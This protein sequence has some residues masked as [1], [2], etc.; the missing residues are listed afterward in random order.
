MVFRW[1]RSAEGLIRRTLGGAEWKQLADFVSPSFFDVMPARALL[2]QARELLGNA[3]NKPGFRSLVAEIG[4][5]L[6]SRGVGVELRA[7]GEAAG[8]DAHHDLDEAGRRARG[9]RVLEI[10]FGQL[11][12]SDAAVIDLRLDRFVGGGD[13]LAWHPGPYWIRWDADFLDGVRRIYEGFYGG[14]DAVFEAALADLHLEAAGDAFRHHFGDGDQ[15]EVRFDPKRFQS[16]FHD[17]FV[18]CRDA[19]ASL[20]PNFL[21]LGCYL[22]ALYDHLGALGGSYDVRGAYERVC[23]DPR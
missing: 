8:T 14:D 11:V 23:A 21:A 16:S 18:R 20:H 2:G 3:S 4:P 17:V 15:R 10:Y 7:G 22:A 6:E 9:Q 12:A 1:A 13:A 19:G 5:E